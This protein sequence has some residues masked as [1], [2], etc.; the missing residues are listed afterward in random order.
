MWGCT[1]KQK[2]GDHFLIL[3]RSSALSPSIVSP[4]GMTGIDC[5][6]QCCAPDITI[7]RY[8]VNI[9]ES[10]HPR[11]DNPII[12]PV[13]VWLVQSY[14]WLNTVYLNLYSLYDILN[15]SSDEVRS[16]L[17]LQTT[18]WKIIKISSFIFRI[19]SCWSRGQYVW[20]LIMRSRARSP[21]LPQILNVN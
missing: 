5:A 4:R 13:F 21:A 1:R 2:T 10:V 7:N 3:R 6:A 14:Q 18:P 9:N 12:V 15:K 20:Q 8:Y 11:G 17:S 19:S 16:R